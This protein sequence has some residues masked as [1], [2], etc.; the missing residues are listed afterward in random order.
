M[1][2]RKFDQFVNESYSTDRDPDISQILAL[3]VTKNVPMDE[4]KEFSKEIELLSNTSERINESLK[5]EISFLKQK[6]ED[7]IGRM[8]KEVCFIEYFDYEKRC[9]NITGYM[10]ICKTMRTADEKTIGER[11]EN[12]LMVKRMIERD[13]KEIA[14]GKQ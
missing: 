3:M 7:I 9:M 10:T 8:P 13:L 2:L 11:Q 6:D 4:I 1:A 5:K 14:G 12:I